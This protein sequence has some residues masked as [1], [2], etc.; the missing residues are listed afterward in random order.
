MVR[1]AIKVKYC[2]S[3]DYFQAMEPKIG[4]DVGNIELS[5]INVGTIM[6]S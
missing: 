2:Y 4:T 1:Q 5:Y 6:T 3:F